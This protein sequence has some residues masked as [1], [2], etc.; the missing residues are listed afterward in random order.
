MI[1]PRKICIVTG[2]RAEY[3]LLFWLM[4]EIQAADGLQLQ[5]IVTG[6]HLSSEFGLTSKQIES[7]GFVINKKV[8]MLLSSDTEVG[9]TKSMGLGMIGFADALNDLNPD[10]MVLLGDRYEIFV[11]AS[12]ATVARICIAHIHG[13]ETTEGAFDESFRHS[14]TKMSHVHFTS[15]DIYRNRVIQLGEHPNRVF[16]VGAAGIDN[17]VRLQLLNKSQFQKEINFQLGKK[18][19]LVTYHPVTLENRT[20]ENQFQALL[21]VLAQ[22]K[23]LKII[24]TKANSDTNGRII[25]NMIDDFVTKYKDQSI[26]FTSMG[27][28]RY[29]SALQFV[30]GVIGNSSSGLIEVPS[31]KIGTVNIGD[32]QLGRIK[33]DS[34]IDC[35]PNQKSIKK[36]IIKLFSEDFKKKSKLVI[37]PYGMGGAAKKIVTELEEISLDGIL[38]KSFYDIEL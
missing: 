5:I 25:N 23:T 16:N 26:S 38:K 22:E 7:D 34:V 2:T 14:I 20:A 3:G 29:L 6:A 36:A 8:D 37:S 19:V 27:Q 1:N 30:D 11:A 9:I 10:L 32:R 17:I 4:K 35:K 18:N 15:T 28:L 21:D 12:A 24:F 31:F 13:G 33:T